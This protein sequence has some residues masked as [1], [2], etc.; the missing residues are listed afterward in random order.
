MP[1]RLM[2]TAS[3]LLQTAAKDTDTQARDT[4]S[5]VDDENASQQAQQARRELHGVRVTI[6]RASYE[7]MFIEF[8]AVLT[9]SLPKGL[10]MYSCSYDNNTLYEAGRLSSVCLMAVLMIVT[11]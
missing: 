6:G 8:P 3:A 7:P 11:P 10:A 5:L 4:I 1:S 2:N 9:P